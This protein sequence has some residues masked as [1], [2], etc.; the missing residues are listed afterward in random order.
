[1]W[2]VF[3][4]SYD[5]TITYS[6]VEIK[7]KYGWVNSVYRTKYMYHKNSTLYASFNVEFC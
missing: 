4:S 5:S 1:W 7:G 2:A 6:S 3:I